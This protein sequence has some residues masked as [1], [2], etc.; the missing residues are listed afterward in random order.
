MFII[1]KKMFF[2]NF[3]NN[4]IFKIKILLN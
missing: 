1:N 3:G 4:D 2:F